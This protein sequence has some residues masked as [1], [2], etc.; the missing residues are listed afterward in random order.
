[1]HAAFMKVKQRC[2]EYFFV[3]VDV[4]W[5]QGVHVCFFAFLIFY[6]PNLRTSK[7]RVVADRN[8]HW[9]FSLAT[10]VT[11]VKRYVGTSPFQ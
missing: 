5:M 10:A 6:Q 8:D 1:M 11:A 7:I 3:D 9:Q 2:I 4:D